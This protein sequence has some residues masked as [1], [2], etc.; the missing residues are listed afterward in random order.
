MQN[1]NTNKRKSRWDNAHN[2]SD[3]ISSELDIKFNNIVTNELPRDTVKR[4]A[5]YRN[6]NH[7]Q[8]QDFSRRVNVPPPPPPPDNRNFRAS[9]V[10]FSASHF[11]VRDG[12]QYRDPY[13][14][15]LNQYERGNSRFNDQLYRE[16]L[17]QQQWYVSMMM[18]FV[19]ILCMLQIMYFAVLFACMYLYVHTTS[20]IYKN[21]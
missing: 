5:W 7:T 21:C 8:Q 19:V 9:D 3:G 4:T 14:P 11:N 1:D 12:G 13:S 18:S 17:Q 6:N 16:Q 2:N 10:P 15:P 20:Y